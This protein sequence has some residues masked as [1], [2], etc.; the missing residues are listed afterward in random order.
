MTTKTIGQLAEEAME[1]LQTPRRPLPPRQLP[2]PPFLCPQCGASLVGFERF[3]CQ[4]CDENRQRFRLFLA[5]RI[6]GALLE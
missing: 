3:L 4:A 1:R 2:P 6:V 5:A